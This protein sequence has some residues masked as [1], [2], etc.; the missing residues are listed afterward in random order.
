MRD[1]DGGLAFARTRAAACCRWFRAPPPLLPSAL[2]SLGPPVTETCPP[3]RLQ[4]D[5][6]STAVDSTPSAMPPTPAARCPS[7]TAT[8]TASSPAPDACCQKSPPH[9]VIGRP[10]PIPSTPHAAAAAATATATAT[11]DTGTGT[12]TDTAN[13]TPTPTPTAHAN[14]PA[15]RVHQD[16]TVDCTLVPASTALQP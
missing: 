16:D 6:N 12:D 11:T 15:V 14:P 4:L 8:T 7:T 5:C 13:A 10:M 2:A 9:S 3:T 1:G